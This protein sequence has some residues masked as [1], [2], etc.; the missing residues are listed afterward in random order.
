MQLLDADIELIVS[1]P[2]GKGRCLIVSNTAYGKALE[3]AAKLFNKNVAFLFCHW[4]LAPGHA[5][6]MAHA[7]SSKI[8]EGVVSAEWAE[9]R[10]RNLN[11]AT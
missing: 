2:P 10:R 4:T 5:R 8:T 11:E 6:T 3:E 7:A 9:T 1:T